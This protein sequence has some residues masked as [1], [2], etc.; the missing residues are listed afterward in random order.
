M[1][2][3]KIMDAVQVYVHTAQALSTTG[4][5]LVCVNFD[6]W[7]SSKCDYGRCP[8]ADAG[9]MDVDI[10]H[11][12]LISAVETLAAA[13]PPLTIR[14]GGSLCDTISYN[15]TAAD[16]TRCAKDFSLDNSSHLGYA[17]KGPCL[18]MK[19]WAQLNQLCARPNCRLAFG[20]NGLAGRRLAAPCAAGTNCKW[21]NPPPKCCTTWEGD[22]D[23]TNALSLMR[24]AKATG[25]TPFAFE[26][27]NEIAGPKGIEAK[28]L[29]PAQYGRDVD[30]LAS[31][32]ASVWTSPEGDADAPPPKVVAYD[33]SY[34]DGYVRAL[35]NATRS[36][37]ILTSHAYSLGAGAHPD[38]VF[39]HATSTATLDAT[40]S[41]YLATASAVAQ[42]PGP[43]RPVPWVGEAGG[44]YNSGAPTVTDAFVSNFWY[45][46]ALG[47]AAVHGFGGW[48][49]QTL[50]GGNYS[51][52]S[53]NTFVP[54]PDYYAALLWRTLMGSTVLSA[55]QGPPAVPALR[56]YAHCSPPRAGANPTSRGDVTVLLLNMAS[57][58]LTVEL[59]IENAA[60][61]ENTTRELWL[62]E[63]SQ[64]GLR[65]SAVLFN[66]ILAQGAA[67]PR[68]RRLPLDAKIL[69]Q[70]MSYAF[71]RTGNIHALACTH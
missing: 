29:D 57:N 33:S 69:L 12:G 5:S 6:W 27:G 3:V 49:R 19:R 59:G 18:Q 55:R 52:L 56:T 32:I 68:G 54:H 40:A 16:A 4:S 66:G 63:A 26:L 8:W 47:N 15:V 11:P 30:T 67:V 38:D 17:L 28:N 64:A 22:W 58:A 1:D 71:V 9:V 45:L 43:K 39:R 25:T 44:A 53:T 42:A 65:A 13:S 20:L 70:P 35:L 2:A 48:C 24:H 60:R 7:P 37:D 34:V 10:T 21:T 31:V 41:E 23:P 14:V 50:V 51:L 46:D 61:S 62:G 36:I